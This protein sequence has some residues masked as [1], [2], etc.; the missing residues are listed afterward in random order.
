[1]KKYLGKNKSLNRKIKIPHEYALIR[2]GLF[3]NITIIVD[4]QQQQRKHSIVRP[5][6]FM[7]IAIVEE[8]IFNFQTTDYINDQYIK[9]LKPI[10]INW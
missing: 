1:M 10:V 6:L 2:P 4:Q 5:N 7:Y 9:K 8:P 3:M